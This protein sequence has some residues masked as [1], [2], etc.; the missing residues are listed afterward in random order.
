MAPEARLTCTSRSLTVSV[1]KSDGSPT[2][3][4]EVASAAMPVQRRVSVSAA[5]F[6]EARAREKFAFDVERP[7]VPLLTV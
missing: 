7:K 3:L 6:T 1:P 2:T 5:S 4:I